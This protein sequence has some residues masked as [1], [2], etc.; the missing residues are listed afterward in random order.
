ML[1][2]GVGSFANNIAEKDL[3]IALLVKPSVASCTVGETTVD[4]YS[5]EP[6]CALAREI[7][8]Q[9]NQCSQQ[10]IDDNN[11]I[12]KAY[13]AKKKQLENMNP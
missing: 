12:L 5:W 4:G 3:E 7:H 10:T 6:L 11:A 9:I 13:R 1:S 8:C 2:F